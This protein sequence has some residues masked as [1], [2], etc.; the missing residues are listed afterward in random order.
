MTHTL[1]DAVTIAKRLEPLIAEKFRLHI[2]IGGSCV[3]R[4]HSEKDVDIFIYPHSKETEIDR[5]KI[6]IWLEEQGFKYRFADDEALQGDF[7]QV[8]DVWV[9]T[10]VAT[11][12]KA[13]FFFLERHTV[14][15][16]KEEVAALCLKSGSNAKEA[17]Q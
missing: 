13:D 8:P 11:G 17:G 9:T 2:A 5:D 10:E 1:Q 14:P 3:Y 4:G 16:P 12:I 15:S 7:T 6:V